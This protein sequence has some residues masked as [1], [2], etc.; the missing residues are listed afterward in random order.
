VK[1]EAKKGGGGKPRLKSAPAV[2]IVARNPN[3]R[4]QCSDKSM[5]LAIEAVKSGLTNIT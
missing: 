3:K 4:K 5:P 1:R 2:L